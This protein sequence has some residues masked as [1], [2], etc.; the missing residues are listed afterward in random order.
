MEPLVE[1]FKE[2]F[3]I[4]II[5]ATCLLVLIIFFRRQVLQLLTYSTETFIYIMLFHGVV[6]LVMWLGRQFKI[7]SAMFD[8]SDPGWS[9][10]TF[11]F[12]RL[13]EYNPRWVAYFELVIFVFI[14]YLVLRYRPMRTQRTKMSKPSPTKRPAVGRG[15]VR[16]AR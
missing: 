4:Y 8:K 11:L 9:T 5:A 6:W 3:K 15:S 12:W 1:H 13:K 16:R 2:N 14:A 10:P 7:A